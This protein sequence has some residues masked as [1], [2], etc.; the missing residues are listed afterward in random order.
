MSDVDA[1]ALVDASQAAKATGGFAA[2]K[3]TLIFASLG[4]IFIAALSMAFA[5]PKSQ[6]EMAIAVCSMLFFAVCGSAFIKVYFGIHLPDDIDGHLA[7]SGLAAVCGA[8]AWLVVRAWFNYFEKN[9]DKTIVDLVKQ[10]LR[11]RKEV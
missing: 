4:G 3:A 6:K 5:T 11:L 9:K 8:P 10:L 2:A 7:N 1:G